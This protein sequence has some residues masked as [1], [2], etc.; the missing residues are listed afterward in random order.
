MKII[1][2]GICVNNIDP[3]GIGRIRCIRYNDYVGE[4]EKSLTYEEW[5]DRDPFVASP[6][7][8]SNISMIP[9]NGQA[10]KII[11][12]STDKET[13]NQEYIA[14]PFTSMYDYNSQT[15]S[16]QIENTTYGVAVK[17]KPDIRNKN[18][19]YIDKSDNIFAKENHY[20][21]YGKYG[22]DVLFTENGL[23]LRGGKLISKDSDNIGLKKRLISYPIESKKVS[24]LSLKKFPTKYYLENKKIIQTNFESK[25]LRTIIEYQIDSLTN[26]TEL[27][28]FIY[29]VQ[30]PLGKTF[31]TN[32]FNENSPLNVEALKLINTDD[33]NTSPTIVI[34]ITSIDDVPSEVRD[35]IFTLHDKNLKEINTLYSEEDLHPFY[36]RPSENFKLLTGTN[37][38]IDKKREILNKIKLSSVGPA[39]GLFWSL[40]SIKP[41]QISQ[42][43]IEKVLKEQNSSIEQTFGSIVSDKIYLLSTDPNETDKTVDFESL[44]KYE[45]TQEDYV[46][47]ID[48]NTYSMV[49]GEN[50]IKLL[51]SVINLLISHEHNVLGPLVKSDDN[52]KIMDELLKNV[53]NDVLNKSIKIN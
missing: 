24:K 47:K 32:Y 1:D 50:L 29:R 34:N 3:K 12:Y 11:N 14:G 37:E 16:Q 40:T 21:I 6:F 36:F 46:E 4:K 38:E 31:K 28:F 22:S 26:P 49:R 44:D 39:S 7:L 17:H 35:I 10:V 15:F 27:K 19:K 9:E 23:Q 53:E 5:S 42:E 13:V 8:P 20:G 41:K 2:I 18:G 52:F 48:P 33:T 51:R 45:Y 43:V 25:D 30:N